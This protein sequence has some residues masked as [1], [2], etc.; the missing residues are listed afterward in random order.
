MDPAVRKEWDTYLL[1]HSTEWFDATDVRGRGYIV[2]H[3]MALV[4]CADEV[5]SP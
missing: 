4:E 5:V 2:S 1:V 3:V